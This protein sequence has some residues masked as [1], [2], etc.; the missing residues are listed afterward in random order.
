MALSS[1]GQGGG[2]VLTPPPLYTPR[3]EVAGGDRR[4]GP[5]LSS[6]L[7][8]CLQ[9]PGVR[10]GG[11]GRTSLGRLWTPWP[12][13]EVVSEVKLLQ[14]S[15][16]LPATRAPHAAVIALQLLLPL[17]LFLRLLCSLHLRGR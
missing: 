1:G 14:V 13:V 17:P 6:T 2:G 3:Q 15:C 7:L 4:P 16:A 9:G 8:F 11:G 5:Q 10:V 12:K